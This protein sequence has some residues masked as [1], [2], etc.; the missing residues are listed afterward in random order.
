MIECMKR[1]PGKKQRK[2]TKSITRQAVDV[3]LLLSIAIFYTGLYSCVQRLSPQES[4]NGPRLESVGD[5]AYNIKQYIK[6]DS[7]GKIEVVGQYLNGKKDGLWRYFVRE[8]LVRIEILAEGKI[9]GVYH[10]ESGSRY[11]GIRVRMSDDCARQSYFNH[12]KLVKEE[13]QCDSTQITDAYYF[14][15]DTTLMIRLQDNVPLYTLV[16]DID[17]R[18]HTIIVPFGDTSNLI[19]DLKQRKYS[20]K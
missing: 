16:S 18:I 6:R 11:E 2:Q 7:L 4:K 9:I 3:L 8:E 12:N 10:P 1:M 13:I 15:G 20:V 5:T 17:K 19:I 14:R